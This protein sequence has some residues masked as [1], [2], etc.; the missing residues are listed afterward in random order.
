V[1]CPAQE[2]FNQAFWAGVEKMGVMASDF[3][4]KDASMV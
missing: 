2:C 4:K 3:L 1:F